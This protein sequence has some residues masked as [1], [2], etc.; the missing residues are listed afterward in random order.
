MPQKQERILRVP[1]RVWPE[2]PKASGG[3]GMLNVLKW[4]IRSKAR[5]DETD[6][7]RFDRMIGV[8]EEVAGET[9]REYEG[10]VKRMR[11]L[12]SRGVNE[13]LYAIKPLS[14]EQ[15]ATSQEDVA[16]QLQHAVARTERLVEQM[17]CQRAL[18]DTLRKRR[19]DG[20]L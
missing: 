2:R 6:T 12:S 3:V 10:L 1:I 15:L 8:L 5:D 14:P 13:T 16:K 17:K 19:A 7:K 4:A 9:S 18:I 20:L 11:E